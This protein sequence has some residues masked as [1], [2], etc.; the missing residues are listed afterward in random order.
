MRIESDRDGE[1]ER[2]RVREEERERE[3]DKMNKYIN[4]VGFYMKYKN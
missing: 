3:R 2:K 4:K 1:E